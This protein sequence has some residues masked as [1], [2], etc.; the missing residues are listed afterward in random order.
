METDKK[1]YTGE[2]PNEY[3]EAVTVNAVQNLE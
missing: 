3:F 2:D 1:E